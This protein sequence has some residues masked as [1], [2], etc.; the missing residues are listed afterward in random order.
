MSFGTGKVWMNGALVRLG[1][2]EDSRRLARRPLRHGRLRG[3]ALLSD[4]EGRGLLPPRRSRRPA[5]RFREDLP[6]GFAAQPRRLGRRRFSTR[7]ARTR[8]RPARPAA[9][10]SRLQPAGGQSVPCPVDMTVLVWEWGAYLGPERRQR[11]RCPRQLV[12][13]DGTEYIP[14]GGQGDRE[15]RQLDADQ[16]GGDAQRLRRG[17]RARHDG[18]R[19]RGQW[20]EPVHR[21][22]ERDLH[23]AD[24]LVD[25][26]WHHARHDP[27]DRARTRLRRARGGAAAR[28]PLSRR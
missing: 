25:S 4:A 27:D 17:D 28:G 16:D 2:R 12:E 13:P 1:R 22:Q 8:W 24:P 18:L 26:W 11:R 14:G 21:A 3:G 15:L 9:D 10:V 6:H 7:F 5:A 23:A 19:Q 20:P